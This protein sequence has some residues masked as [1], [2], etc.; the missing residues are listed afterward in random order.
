MNVWWHE[1]RIFSKHL[2]SSTC[3]ALAW[4][5]ASHWLLEA[6]GPAHSPTRCWVSSLTALRLRTLAKVIMW[7]SYIMPGGYG[8]V[9]EDIVSIAQLTFSWLKLR[10]NWDDP[11][12]NLVPICVEPQTLLLCVANTH[13]HSQEEE[14]NT[15]QLV[16]RQIAQVDCWKVTDGSRRRRRRTERLKKQTTQTERWRSRAQTLNTDL[17]QTARQG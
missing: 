3:L 15:K 11:H 6:A 10:L 16:S 5:L 1:K 14:K 12:I 17:Q 4:G 2:F 9:S 8:L 13:M 7:C